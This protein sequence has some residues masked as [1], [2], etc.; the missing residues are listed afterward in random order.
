MM[1]LNGTSYF[2][3]TDFVD[4]MHIIK[5]QSKTPSVRSKGTVLSWGQ[6]LGGHRTSV[7]TVE[8]IIEQLTNIMKEG[9]ISEPAMKYERLETLCS[10][11]TKLV[12]PSYKDAYQMGRPSHNLSYSESMEYDQFI[13]NCIVELVL[14]EFRF[15]M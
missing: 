6:L 11:L 5:Y 1:H 10:K 7:L 12:R 15:Y 14:V 3:L 8:R 9:F 2:E 13:K 4:I